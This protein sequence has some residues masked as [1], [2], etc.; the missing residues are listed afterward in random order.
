MYAQ[1]LDSKLE[2]I[3]TNSIPLTLSLADTSGVTYPAIRYSEKRSQPPSDPLLR[4][5]YMRARRI[6]AEFRS[7]SKGSLARYKNKIEDERVLKNEVGWAVLGRLMQD[8]VLSLDGNWYYLNPAALNE[9]LGLTWVDLRKGRMPQ[10]LM[11]YL[12]TVNVQKP[13]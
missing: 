12:K 9:H 2:N 6:L 1:Q 4:Q 11:D 3:L 7:H 10:K 8:K 5:K 13:K